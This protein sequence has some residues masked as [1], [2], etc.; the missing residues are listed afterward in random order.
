MGKFIDE[1]EILE[2]VAENWLKRPSANEAA[3]TAYSEMGRKI[4]GKLI[5]QL[6]RRI[7]RKNWEILLRMNEARSRM[8]YFRQFPT[9]VMDEFRTASLF[10]L[11]DTWE[12]A[13][14]YFYDHYDDAHL[15]TEELKKAG[16]KEDLKEVMSKVTALVQ[17][18]ISALAEDGQVRIPLGEFEMMEQTF[19]GVMLFILGRNGF[20]IFASEFNKALPILKRVLS[21]LSLRSKKTKLSPNKNPV[22]FCPQK[23]RTIN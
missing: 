5:G 12:T 20:E 23:N 17:A 2:I 22:L 7:T 18:H 1:H 8:N 21:E 13:V 10:F 15:E 16:S 9:S 19:G 11:F 14:Q 6:G 4:L 3:V